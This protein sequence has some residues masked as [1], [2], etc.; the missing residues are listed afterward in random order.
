MI[1]VKRG[2]WWI[3]TGVAV[4]VIAVA[5]VV[6]MVAA[7][8]NM[9]QDLA[10]AEAEA[11]AKRANVM[12]GHRLETHDATQ[13][14]A[15]LLEAKRRAE[16]DATRKLEAEKASAPS[17]HYLDPHSAG[18]SPAETLAAKRRAEEAEARANGE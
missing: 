2:T 1:Q 10:K 16:A 8:G 5:G 7:G 13:S 9:K 14:N 12:A 6:H 17:G 11:K 4:L 3:V 15:E 18:L